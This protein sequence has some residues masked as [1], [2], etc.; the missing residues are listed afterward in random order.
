MKNNKLTY[1]KINDYI[2]STKT[3]N[4][5]RLL[6]TEDEFE[7][8]KNKQGKTNWDVKLK[9]KCICG[10]NFICNWNTFTNAD[11]KQCNKCSGFEFHTYEEVKKYIEIESNSNCKWLDL[12]YVNTKTNLN[13]EC[14]CGRKFITTLKSFLIGKQRC[15]ICSGN[16]YDIRVIKEW[17]LKNASNIQVMD[18]KYINANS[19]LTFKTSRG[20]VF[21]KTWSNFLRNPY[22][23]EEVRF[24]EMENYINSK[25]GFE[26]I[27]KE[28]VPYNKKLTIKCPKHHVF[29]MK[30]DSF[31]KGSSCPYCLAEINSEK[32]RTPIDEVYRLINNK[33]FIFIKWIDEYRNAKSKFIIQCKDCGNLIRSNP[34]RIKKNLGCPICGESKGEK[35][36][37]S[38]LEKNHIFFNPQQPFKDC[39]DKKEMPFDFATFEDKAKIELNYLIEY[40]GIFHYEKQYDED[41]YEVLIKHDKMKNNYCI[42]N[43][44]KLIR[45]PYWDFEKIEEIL[46]DILINDNINSNYII[47]NMEV[48]TL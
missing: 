34:W 12:A 6:Y 31:H 7:E 24:E 9:I 35:A 46:T 48:K 45:I 28:F 27:D 39:K 41:G 10:N 19:S 1:K 42:R 40:D 5:C 4:G 47:N 29:N 21:K 37:R 8:E 30:F 14:H 18:E 11:K 26:L 16:A 25:D 38:F 3:G 13:L 44:I 15:D 23:H 20:Y 2:N 32:L 22:C 36:V 43:N 17:L 33:N